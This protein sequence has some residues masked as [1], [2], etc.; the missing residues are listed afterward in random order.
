MRIAPDELSFT[1]PQAWPQIY[2]S[3]PQLKKTDFHFAP[4]DE[5]RLPTSMITAPDAEHTRLRRLTAPAFLSAGIKEV[6]PVLQRYT[7]LLCSQLADASREGSQNLVEWFLWTLNDVI[8]QLARMSI[9]GS[10]SGW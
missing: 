1:D 10:L 6:E 7:E 8:G 3:R 9:C 5:D 2:N 4:N